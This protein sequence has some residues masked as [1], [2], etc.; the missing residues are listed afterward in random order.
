MFWSEW[1]SWVPT[2]PCFVLACVVRLVTTGLVDGCEW[3][4]Q[5]A[6]AEWSPDRRCDCTVIESVRKNPEYSTLFLFTPPAVA[7]QYTIDNGCALASYRR[8]IFRRG[9]SVTC[10]LSGFNYFRTGCSF[11][12]WDRRPVVMPAISRP[13]ASWDWSSMRRRSAISCGRAMGV[14]SDRLQQQRES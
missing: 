12:E 14:D 8:S 1:S 2:R 11:V 7:L 4:A 10:S 3:H 13:Y 6:D 9:Q 5:I